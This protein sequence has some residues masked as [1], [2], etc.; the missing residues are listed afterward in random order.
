MEEHRGSFSFVALD[1][2]N[3]TSPEELEDEVKT[4]YRDTLGMEPIDKPSGTRDGGAWFRAGDH[5]VHVSIDEHNPPKTAHFGLVVQGYDAIIERLRA[6]GCH[7]EQA[8]E[9]PGR[10]RFYTRDPAGNRI[11]IMS[12]D[13]GQQG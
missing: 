11:E 1:H 4:W 3:V 10:H 2:V 12:F 13:N 7:I 8:R 5:E 9:I 6:A